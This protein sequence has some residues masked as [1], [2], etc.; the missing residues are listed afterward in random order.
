MASTTTQP[1]PGENDVPVGRLAAGRVSPRPP[2]DERAVAWPEARRLA[3]RV[4]PL[5]ACS[6]PLPQA[7]GRALAEDVTAP[8]SRCPWSDGRSITHRCCPHDIVHK[9]AADQAPH[10]APMRGR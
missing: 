8:T 9:A 1:W 3:G 10:A 2:P 7:C 4:P 6:V 5:A